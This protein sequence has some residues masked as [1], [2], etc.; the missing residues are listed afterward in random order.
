MEDRP[1]CL[2][3]GQLEERRFKRVLVDGAEPSFDL[4]I[5]ADQREC[6]LGR[7]VEAGIH[8]PRVVADLRK[9]QRVAVDE[10]LE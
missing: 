5:T 10:V 3:R 2:R 1:W 8:S 7:D 9:G 4:A 6:R